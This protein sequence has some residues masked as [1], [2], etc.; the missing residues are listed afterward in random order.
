MVNAWENATAAYDSS[1]GWEIVILRWDELQPGGPTDWTPSEELDEY[2]GSARAAGREVVGVLVGTPSWAT[3]DTPGIGVPTG[4]YLPVDDGTNHWANFVKR[5]AS[6]YGSRGISRW[7]IWKDP[8]IPSNLPTATWGGSIE[9]YYQLVKTA[10]IAARDASPGVIIHLGGVGR[11]DPQWFARFL[12]LALDDPSA[13][14]ND[15]YFDVATLHIFNSPDAVHSLM[16][17]HFF[18]MNQKGIPLKEVWLNETGASPATDPDTYV[19]SVDFRED[20]NIT[21]TEQ[22]GFIVKSFAMAFAANRGA[23]VAV[24]RMRDDLAADG[25]RA[26]GLVRE[27][28]STRLAYDTYR[29]ASREF[30]GF[31]FARRVDE[32]SAPLIDYVRLTHAAKVTHVAWA[33]TNQNAT[34]VIPAR[35]AQARLLDIHG[36]EWTV[37]PEGG[38][39]RLAVAA[40]D[41]DDPPTGCLFGGE[42]WLLV[43]ENVADAVNDT[44]PPV[45]VEPG[46]TPPTPD[47]DTLLTATALAEP[48]ATPTGEA[49]P[50]LDVTATPTADGVTPTEDVATSDAPTDP[51]A[52]V[53]L[54]APAPT[55]APVMPTAEEVA[56]VPP[57]DTPPQDDDVIIVDPR[58]VQPGGLRGRYR[59]FLSVLAW[60]SLASARG[61][62][63]VADACPSARRYCCRR[64]RQSK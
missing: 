3:A 64:G 27:D 28:G 32:Q 54:E 50:T 15:Y 38:Q 18:L 42:P 31:I 35:S 29:L 14:A 41:C 21:Q 57:D 36:N 34:L 7:V 60:C 44:P 51:T 11:A 39:Y 4:L 52:T 55:D 12:E 8:D 37:Q 56:E 48:T 43:E 6:Y 23:R 59:S 61:T 33:I 47:P 10:Y 26:Y 5:A 13:P 25:G 16:A 22:A 19:D 17:N 46:G 30:G 9:E 40:G 58:D 24:Y 53:D 1:A 62:S 2:L 63:S 49:T 45:S 20:P